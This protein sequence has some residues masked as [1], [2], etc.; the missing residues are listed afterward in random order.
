MC[1]RRGKCNLF[2]PGL[3]DSKPLVFLF[4]SATRPG[5][6]CNPHL[7]GPAPATFP[8]SLSP[9]CRVYTTAGCTP[10]CPQV[11]A[12]VVP[13]GPD[14]RHGNAF[15]P[16]ETDLTRTAMACRDQAPQVIA[17]PAA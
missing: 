15:R 9:H 4:P 1:G 17:G 11:D 13:L 10:H 2:I 7:S 3:L 14:N 8:L 5:C 16:K 6:A 12:E